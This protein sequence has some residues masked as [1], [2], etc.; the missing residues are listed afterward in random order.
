MKHYIL[1][2][3]FCVAACGEK[4]A[5]AKRAEAEGA[6]TA[7]GGGVAIGNASRQFLTI[8]VLAPSSGA[9]ERSYFGRTAFRPRA[10]SAV[11]A[12]FSGRVASVTAEPGQRVKAGT[13]LFTV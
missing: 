4:P 10:L 2:L 6:K 12:P 3:A 5:P 1:A 8:E 11:T 7:P 13:T 9:S